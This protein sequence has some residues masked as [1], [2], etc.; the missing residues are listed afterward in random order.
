MNKIP[1]PLPEK[2][3]D[4]PKMSWSAPFGRSSSQESLE[5][6]L[7][8]IYTKC[9]TFEKAIQPRYQII[10]GRKGV[11]KSSLIKR[12]RLG[13][14][15][16]IKVVCEKDELFEWLSTSISPDLASQGY[17]EPYIKKCE[18]FYWISIFR[19]IS[20]HKDL[21]AV[22]QFL[23]DTKLSNNRII[24]GI[25]E[26]ASANMQSSNPLTSVSA[27]LINTFTKQNNPNFEKA[28]NQAKEFLSNKKAVI[29]IDN[30][31][32]YNF[33]SK[34]QQNALSALLLSSVSFTESG[35]VVVKCFIPSEYYTQLKDCSINFGKISQHIIAL[36][37]KDRELLSMM[38]K[39]LGFYLFING[40]S[41]SLDLSEF[42]DV[43]KALLF[44]AKYFSRKVRNEAFDVD[45]PVVTYIL[46]HTQ[47]TP[48]QVIQLCNSIVDEAENSFPQKRISSD[49]IRFGIEK[50]EKKLC[51][52]IFS[53]F[54]ENYPFSE[55][56]CTQYLRNLPMSF[57]LAMLR[58][59]VFEVID[60]STDKYSR[61][62][63]SYIYF[64]KMLFELGV[65]GKEAAPRNQNV[66]SIYS[67][68]NMSQF[69]PNIDDR[70]NPNDH[71]DLYVH[72]MF[73]HKIN[74]IRDKKACAKPVCSI[75]AAATP[76]ILNFT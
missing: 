7:N 2:P 28:K 57:R 6:A 47:L 43:G 38:C 10:L 45:E 20:R 74:F 17:I 13:N 50:Y 58:A 16:D 40:C 71:T 49:D 33:N 44:W 12:I 11:G 9:E 35:S 65:I 1:Q 66:S 46:R 51:V 30:I 39:R 75:Q 21:G 14:E 41:P 27:G 3:D 56:F 73:I 15:Y 4:L 67:T 32:R 53:S 54:Q 68:Y 72:P 64:E 42:E 37:W 31:E 18:I 19:E 36:R 25:Q 24:S 48:R 5:G 26:W 8:F 62:K 55:D 22:S 60:D 76:E 29:L 34:S 23:Q 59:K 61:Y 52:E 63:E 70:L 69:E